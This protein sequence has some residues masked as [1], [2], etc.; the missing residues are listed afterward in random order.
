MSKPFVFDIDYTCNRSTPPLNGSTAHIK[1]GVGNAAPPRCYNSPD[2]VRSIQAALNRFGPT[3]GGPLEP[4]KEDGICGPKT[5]DAIYRFQKVWE[6][7][8]TGWK[9]PDGI[10][11]PGG[12]TIQRLNIGAPRPVDLPTEF[13]ARIPRALEIITATRAA[14]MLAK[15]YLSR[16]K[17]QGLPAFGAIGKLEAERFEKHFHVSTKPNPV[18]R[19]DSIDGIFLNMQRAIGHIPQGMIVALP[20]PAALGWG[21]F[22]FTWEGSYYRQTPDEIDH[23]YTHLHMGS[24]YLCPKSKLL[25]PESFAYGMIHEL[26]HYAGPKSDGFGINDKA[27]FMRTPQEYRRLTAD[28]AYTNA[29]SYAQLAFEMIGKPDFNIAQNG[30][31]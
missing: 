7:F 31:V 27:Y 4:L 22:M 10:V 17:G 19:L 25:G 8:P 6:L 30:C 16:P 13:A 29:D 1:L 15:R 23:D 14:L 2:D 24:I 28:Q 5:K 21:A 12:K 3:D 9:Q 18:Q 26:A 11:D 20:E